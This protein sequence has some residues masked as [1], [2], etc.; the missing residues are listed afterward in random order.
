[1]ITPDVGSIRSDGAKQTALGA[2]GDSG[3]SSLAVVT[4]VAVAAVP[5]L[6]STVR[7]LERDDILAA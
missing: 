4:A 5:A 6:A 2:R 1:M 3:R 7:M